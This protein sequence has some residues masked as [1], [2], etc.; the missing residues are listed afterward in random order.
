MAEIH[1]EYDGSYFT[2]EQIAQLDDAFQ[3]DIDAMAADEPE[4]E[5]G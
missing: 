3:A 2:P 5:A 4:P 1:S